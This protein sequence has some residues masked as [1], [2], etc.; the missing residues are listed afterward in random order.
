MKNV[1][2]FFTIAGKATIRKSRRKW[3]S[4]EE[5]DG[6]KN[7]VQFFTVARGKRSYRAIPDGKLV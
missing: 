6:M 3:F 4:S 7:E 1:P 2:Q 5:V